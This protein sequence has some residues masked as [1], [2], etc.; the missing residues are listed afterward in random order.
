LL[1]WLTDQVKIA[2]TPALKWGFGTISPPDMTSP[3][4][5]K[6]ICDANCDHKNAEEEQKCPYFHWVHRK[7]IFEK[8]VSKDKRTIAENVQKQTTKKNVGREA[9]VS[10]ALKGVVC[11]NIFGRALAGKHAESTVEMICL[12]GPTTVSGYFVKFSPVLLKCVSGTFSEAKEMK[13]TVPFLKSAVNK[14]YRFYQNLHVDFG[15]S[16]QEY[17]FCRM[18]MFTEFLDRFY[19][20]FSKSNPK[21][22]NLDQVVTFLQLDDDRLLTNCNAVVYLRKYPSPELIDL[23]L[24]AGERVDNYVKALEHRA[25]ET[26]SKIPVHAIQFIYSLSSYVDIT[27]ITMTISTFSQIYWDFNEEY[28]WRNLIHNKF[29]SR[30]DRTLIVNLLPSGGLSRKIM[31]FIAALISNNIQIT[32]QLVG[33][34]ELCLY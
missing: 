21:F 1:A 2:S 27:K 22:E 14:V 7:T 23:K 9:K 3:L 24:T 17:Q 12:D 31:R 5:F 15:D 26:K 10:I 13:I 16:E 8:K 32:T 18:Y 20:Y 33:D 29:L 28:W 4:N 30:A 19:T 34:L 11:S 6:T 25:T